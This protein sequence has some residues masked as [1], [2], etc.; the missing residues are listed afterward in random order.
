MV[1][2]ARNQPALMKLLAPLNC[3]KPLHDKRRGRDSNPRYVLPYT[4]FPVPHLRPLGHLSEAPPGLS[5][6]RRR[7]PPEG[8][9]VDRTDGPPFW[10]SAY[11]LVVVMSAKP[12]AGRAG[13]LSRLE[14][15]GCP[16]T[17]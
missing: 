11:G 15:E 6:R 8:F 9:C 13:R 17:T 5:H 16:A 4:A 2:W 7:A 14:A 10:Q 12:R 1:K 3:R